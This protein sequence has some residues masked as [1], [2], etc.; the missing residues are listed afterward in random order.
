M[1][2]KK[3]LKNLYDEV[4]YLPVA[5]S[6][7]GLGEIAAKAVAKTIA[8]SKAILGFTDKPTTEPADRA[9]IHRVNSN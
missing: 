4:D 1:Q 5:S 7:K 6:I 2:I 8:V 3:F 9:T